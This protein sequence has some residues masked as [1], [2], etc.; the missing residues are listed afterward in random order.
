MR[1]IK[2]YK[3]LEL[4]GIEPKLKKLL[5]KSRKYDRETYNETLWR[6]IKEHLN[7]K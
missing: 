6:I 2:K 4:I 5:D 7:K 3:K 1:I